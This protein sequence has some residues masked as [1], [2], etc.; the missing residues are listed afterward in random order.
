M[1]GIFL[2][3]A[4]NYDTNQ[5]SI[6]SGLSCSDESRTDQSF[7]EECDINTIVRDFGVTGRLPDNPIKTPLEGDFTAVVDYQTALNMVLEADAAFSE[8]PSA[9]RE[10]FGNDAAR[11]VAFA[12]DPEN[13]EECRKL[14]LADPAPRAPEPMQVRVV[15]DPPAASPPIASTTTSAA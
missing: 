11:F 6:S 5:A 12:S 3:N 14:G 10:R 8:L 4:Y 15:S 1:P 13:L 7:I 2:R 9:V